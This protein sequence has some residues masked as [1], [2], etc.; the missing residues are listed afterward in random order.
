MQKWIAETT[1]NGE[2]QPPFPVCAPSF[3][4]A[5]EILKKNNY[6][7]VSLSMCVA[8]DPSVMLLLETMVKREA[9]AA[10]RLSEIASSTRSPQL[11]KPIRRGVFVAMLWMLGLVFVFYTLLQIPEVMLQAEQ[12]RIRLAE[13]YYS[14]LFDEA[15]DAYQTEQ[16]RLNEIDRKN[17]TTTPRKD[18]VPP[19]RP[20]PEQVA[21][22]SRR[23]LEKANEP[24][25]SSK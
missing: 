24:E 12:R 11:G 4:A 1:F 20:T 14:E 15:W 9:E 10:S 5:L 21:E 17:Y 8:L 16:L 13:T 3:N 22:W 6:E 7:V 19:A 23:S 2:A 18:F 25:P